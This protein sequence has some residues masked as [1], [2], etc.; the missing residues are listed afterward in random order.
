MHQKIERILSICYC[1]LKSCMFA[2]TLNELTV[3]FSSRCEELG[4]SSEGACWKETLL[5]GVVKSCL[6]A[7]SRTMSFYALK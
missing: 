3:S 7:D 1:K 5:A 6:S 2:I 4:I